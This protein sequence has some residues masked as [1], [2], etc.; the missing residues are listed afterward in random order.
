MEL[1]AHVTINNHLLFCDV[2]LRVSASAGP[3]QGDN[4][5]RNT[6]RTSAVK[7]VTTVPLQYEKYVIQSNTTL[8]ISFCLKSAL[9]TSQ[10]T[11]FGSHIEPSSGLYQE[12]VIYSCMLAKNYIFLI[13]YCRRNGNASH[14]N[15]IKTMPLTSTDTGAL[16]S[17]HCCVNINKQLWKIL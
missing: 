11:C 9:I 17:V 14:K 6:V 5:Q 2:Q 4:S 12:Y 3:P 7:D 1:M 15:R 16:G 8:V 10:N 13:L